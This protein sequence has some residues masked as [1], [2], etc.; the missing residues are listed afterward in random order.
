MTG[1]RS[2]P[3]DRYYCGRG[4]GD[5]ESG[6]VLWLPCAVATGDGRG[7]RRHC[8]VDDCSCCHRAPALSAQRHSGAAGLRCFG[9]ATQDHSLISLI[10]S[11]PIA[12]AVIDAEIITATAI[13]AALVDNTQI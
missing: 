1:F 2:P 9:R 6:A 10:G 7:V 12:A 8:C 11:A 5:P 3:P 4:G 13:P